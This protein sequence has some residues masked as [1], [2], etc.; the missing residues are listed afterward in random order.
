MK[1]LTSENFDNEIAEGSAPV[2]VDFWA[3]WC[4][5]CRAQAPILE[6]LQ[7]ELGNNVK[8][9]KVN[10]DENPDLCKRF[11]IMSIPS[12]IFFRDGNQVDKV[13]GLKSID[14]L[15]VLLSSI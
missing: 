13:V 10:V 8:I 2:I 1:E 14:E 5:P 9:C 12:L 15:K 11:G 3:T 6:Q 4:G 7:T